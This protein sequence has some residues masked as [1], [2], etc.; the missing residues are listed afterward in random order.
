MIAFCVA[1]LVA[2]CVF[3][4]VEAVSGEKHIRKV[5]VRYRSVG[6]QAA[7]RLEYQLVETDKGLGLLEKRLDHDVHGLLRPAWHDEKG[8][9]FIYWVYPESGGGLLVRVVGD[10]QRQ[11][12][13]F[14]FVI[15][16]DRTEEGR[17][18]IYWEYGYTAKVEN[19]IKKPIAKPGSPPDLIRLIPY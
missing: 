3:D 1:L 16:D 14:E 2:G 19:G 15:P 8:D 10:V 7:T 18:Y 17:E 4:Q 6:V 5:I 12:G 9:H 11:I 13:V